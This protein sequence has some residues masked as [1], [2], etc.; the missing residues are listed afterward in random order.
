MEPE[1]AEAC[2]WGLAHDAVTMAVFA[3]VM[4]F[5]VLSMSLLLMVWLWVLRH[6]RHRYY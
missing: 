4:C 5:A 2:M 6:P 3:L 1:A